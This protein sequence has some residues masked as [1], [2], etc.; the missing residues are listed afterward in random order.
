MFLKLP[1]LL[2]AA[3]STWALAHTEIEASREAIEVDREQILRGRNAFL[4]ETT[5]S[6]DTPGDAQ[7]IPSQQCLA[8]QLRPDVK[9][10]GG[11]RPVDDLILGRPQGRLFEAMAVVGP[12]AGI[13]DPA[14]TTGSSVGVTISQ[15]ASREVGIL[16]GQNRSADLHSVSSTFDSTHRVPQMEGVAL[17]NAVGLDFVEQCWVEFESGATFTAEGVLVATLVPPNGSRVV[18][19]SLL[20]DSDLNRNPVADFGSRS[21]RRAWIILGVGLAVA[22]SSRL[23]F[24]RRDAIVYRSLGI[25]LGQRIGLL[26]WPAALVTVLGAQF[27]LFAASWIARRSSPTVVDQSVLL[28]ASVAVVRGVLLSLAIVL[29]L[30]SLAAR[31]A[32]PEH[33][34]E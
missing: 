12:V 32:S 33:L 7:L 16:P 31:F 11:T 1:I 18:Y 3:A 24:N 28:I 13:W 17:V 6:S 8:L 14:A 10:S 20:I 22:A 19:R 5:M 26:F 15:T 30:T 27:G 29:V 21:S 4:A 25:R 34:R 23:W 9:A 2:L